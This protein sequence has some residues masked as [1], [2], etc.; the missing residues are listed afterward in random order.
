[1]VNKVSLKRQS[2]VTAGKINPPRHCGPGDIKELKMRALNLLTRLM[3]IVG[4]IKGLLVGIKD[5]DLCSLWRSAGPAVENRLRP[6]WPVG[7]LPARTVLQGPFYRWA[8]G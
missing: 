3:M 5:C 2:F 7:P 4:G 6:G 8:D 1:M